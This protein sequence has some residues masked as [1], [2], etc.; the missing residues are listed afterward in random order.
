MIFGLP[1]RGK[2]CHFKVDTCILCLTQ[3]KL[4][5]KLKPATAGAR[6]LSVDGG[7]IRGVKPL[8]FLGLLQASVGSS[9]QVQDLFEQAFGTSSG[10]SISFTN[11]NRTKRVQVAL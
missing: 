7:G 10:M 9:L 3:G 5:A 2:E 6:I 11:R 8:E 4:I 1:V